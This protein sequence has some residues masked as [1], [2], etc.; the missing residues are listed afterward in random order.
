M[1]IFISASVLPGP[2][3][4]T[5][6]TQSLQSTGERRKG[7]VSGSLAALQ[8]VPVQ[9]DSDG[10]R[11]HTLPLALGIFFLPIPLSR[12]AA[13]VYELTQLRLPQPE[14]ATQLKKH[15]RSIH[16]GART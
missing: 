8:L 5:M 16:H 4:R 13:E 15:S 7:L 14:A 3:P 10:N 9:L 1:R 12:L 6:Q 2:C 11:L